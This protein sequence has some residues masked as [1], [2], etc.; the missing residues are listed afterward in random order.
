[1]K[2]AL[3]ERIQAFLGRKENSTLIGSPASPEEIAHAQELLTIRFHADYLHFIQAFGGAYAGL[4]VHAFSNGSS[5]GNETVVE[6][7]LEFR[8]QCKD[9]PL[10]EILQTS[11]VISLDGS[12][13]PIFINQ[14]GEACICYHDTGEIKRLADS[15]EALIEEHFDEW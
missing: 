12:G 13:D 11:Y 6:L 4:A 5:I 9:S 10:A 15:F 7:T 3:L 1:M 2:E 14:A 8:E